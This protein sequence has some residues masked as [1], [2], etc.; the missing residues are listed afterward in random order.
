MGYAASSG[1]DGVL[2]LLD[3]GSCDEDGGGIGVTNVGTGTGG[4]ESGRT[5]T[6]RR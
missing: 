6:I 4:A 1:G 3:G 5:L 2:V